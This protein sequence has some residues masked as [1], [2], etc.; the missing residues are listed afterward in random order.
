MSEESNQLFYY[1]LFIVN[2]KY[3][4]LYVIHPAL[5]PFVVNDIFWDI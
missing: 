4:T 3:Y 1:V 2:G 5:I